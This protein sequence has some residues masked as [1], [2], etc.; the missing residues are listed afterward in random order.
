[1][2]KKPIIPIILFVAILLPTTLS[3]CGVNPEGGSSEIG[4]FFNWFWNLIV[5]LSSGMLN[6]L[7]IFVSTI[8]FSMPLGLLVCFAR[9]S[10]FKVIE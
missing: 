3:A 2:K 10:K 7:L 6:S 8:I 4:Q 5:E 9:R 1:M